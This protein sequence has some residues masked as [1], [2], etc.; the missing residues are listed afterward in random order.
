MPVRTVGLSPVG[1]SGGLINTM[2]GTA[3]E[4]QGLP[5]SVIGGIVLDGVAVASGLPIAPVCTYAN[6]T[7]TDTPCPPCFA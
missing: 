3:Y 1:F 6:G 2:V 5:E 7:C 4:F